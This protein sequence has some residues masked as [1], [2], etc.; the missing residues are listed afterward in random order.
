[1]RAGAHGYLCGSETPEVLGSVLKSLLCGARHFPQAVWERIHILLPANPMPATTR[2]R[3]SPAECEFLTHLAAPDHPTCKQVAE[4][5]G[6]SVYA[7]EKYRNEM[8]IRYGVRGKAGLID[9]AKEF[10]LA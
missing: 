8:C 7:I 6:R 9:L 1:M 10:G 4:R 2:R 3:P 5:T